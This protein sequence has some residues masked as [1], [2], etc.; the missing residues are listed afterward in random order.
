MNALP[1]RSLLLIGLYS[2]HYFHRAL[3]SP[4]VLAPKRAPL[5][6]MVVLAG[7]IFNGLN[8]TLLAYQLAEL[9]PKSDCLYWAGV[10]LWGLGFFGNGEYRPQS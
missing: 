3:L 2:A 5:H 9:E 8:G 4:L 1:G 7:F 10:T 6:I